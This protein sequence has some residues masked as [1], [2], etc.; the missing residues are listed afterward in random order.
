MRAPRRG[1]RPAP[2]PAARRGSAGGP[3]ARRSRRLRVEGRPRR[4]TPGPGRHRD[5]RE[6]RSRVERVRAARDEARA[7]ALGLEGGVDVLELRA[8]ARHARG[9][10][11]SAQG[12]RPAAWAREGLAGL[13][14]LRRGR[15]RARGGPGSSKWSP[16]TGNWVRAWRPFCTDPAS[17]WRVAQALDRSDAGRRRFLPWPRPARRH[18]GATGP[19]RRRSRCREGGRPRGEGRRDVPEPDRARHPAV[20]A[21][22]DEGARGA[23]AEGADG[24]PV[25]AHHGGGAAPAARVRD[26]GGLPRGRREGLERGS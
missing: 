4:G 12:V 13:R 26:E 24:R 10:R 6:R 11:R 1:G 25:A 14:R 15:R 8:R 2:G 5:G 22:G 23:V 17:P 21:H 3:D 16:S 19:E 9:P 20:D 7:V 18:A